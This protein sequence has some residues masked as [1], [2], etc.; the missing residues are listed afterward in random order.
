VQA[1]REISRHLPQGEDSPECF[2]AQRLLLDTSGDLL[3]RFDETG[4]LKDEVARQNQTLTEQV[5]PMFY[6]RDSIGIPRQWLGRIRRAWVTLAA[7][8]STDRM[9]REY[10][11][12]YYLTPWKETR[13]AAPE[14]AHPQA[15]FL[16]EVN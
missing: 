3:R 11:T 2:L 5:I 14:P 10:C 16:K 6:N 9:V 7:Q 1:L 8:Y 4:K 15:K 12:K 13:E